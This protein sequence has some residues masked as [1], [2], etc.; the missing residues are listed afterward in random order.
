M[1]VHLAEMVQRV[2]RKPV[3]DRTGIEGKFDLSLQ[4]EEGRPESLLEI[5]RAL[6]FG[7]E[8]AKLPTEFLVLS[9]KKFLR[10]RWIIL[11]FELRKTAIGEPTLWT[12]GRTS[13]ATNWKWRGWPTRQNGVIGWN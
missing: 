3:V 6:G 8:A 9:K 4:Y 1:Q 11:A 13:C 7:I 12:H 2:L 10:T 5:L